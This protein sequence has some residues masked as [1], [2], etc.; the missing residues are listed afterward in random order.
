MTTALTNQVR[1]P[2]YQAARA[3]ATT[4]EAHFAEHIA[5]AHKRGD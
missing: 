2:T 5:A 1:D 4:I 3:V